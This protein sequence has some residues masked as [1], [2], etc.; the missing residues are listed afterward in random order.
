ME[1]A[2]TVVRICGGVDAVS[3]MAGRHRTRVHR[4]GQPKDKGG[5]GGVIPS[6]VRDELLRSALAAGIPLLPEHF[7]PLELIDAI[8]AAHK[9]E[10]AV[11]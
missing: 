8:N 7:H 11:Q 6:D 3:K 9:T 1:P 5:C 2:K 10:E 4:W